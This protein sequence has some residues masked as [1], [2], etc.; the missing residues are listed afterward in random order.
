MKKL[1]STLLIAS[2]TTCAIPALSAF[3]AEST[4]ILSQ[5]RYELEDATLTKDDIRNGGDDT[6]SGGKFVGGFDNGEQTATLTVTAPKAGAYALTVGFITMDGGR[7]FDV[8]VNGKTI[9]NV[10]CGASGSS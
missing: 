10:T 8:T 3:A 4:D 9:N 1:L 2:M 6:V 7:Q 5:P